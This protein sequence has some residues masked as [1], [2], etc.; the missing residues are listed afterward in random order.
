MREIKFRAWDGNKK[1]I[2]IL[3]GS[4]ENCQCDDCPVLYG[5]DCPYDVWEQ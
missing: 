5:D 3:I 4:G 2:G 1:E